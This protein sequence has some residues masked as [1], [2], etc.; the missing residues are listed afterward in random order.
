MV[1]VLAII[2]VAF[3]STYMYYR[4]FE[5]RIITDEANIAALI[6]KSVESGGINFL[7]NMEN[8]SNYRITC[9]SGDGSVLYDSR[10]SDDELGSMSNHMDRPEVIAATGKHHIRV[11][12]F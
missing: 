4:T 10:I 3:L 7:K 12:A 5:K 2:A 9:I 6:K 8:R 1:A 11:L